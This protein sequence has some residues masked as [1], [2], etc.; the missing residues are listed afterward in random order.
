[1]YFIVFSRKLE[2]ESEQSAWDYNKYVIGPFFVA[3]D[4]LAGCILIE[5]SVA[6]MTHSFS[7]TKQEF[8]REIYKES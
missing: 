8:D 1:M 4:E 6:A 3:A 5:N 7:L 2:W